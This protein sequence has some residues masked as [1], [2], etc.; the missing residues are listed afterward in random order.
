MSDN[1]F[2]NL[3][4]ANPR[5]TTIPGAMGFDDEDVSGTLQAELQ[6][7]VEGPT[8]EESGYQPGDEGVNAPPAPEGLP[9][10]LDYYC[11]LELTLV[12]REL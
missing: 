6:G 1:I 10:P 5:R 2:N 3:S 4:G 12:T 7:T 11:V 8:N 9:S